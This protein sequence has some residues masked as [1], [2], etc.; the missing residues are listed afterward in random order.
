MTIS[1]NCDHLS[2]DRACDIANQAV[3]VGGNDTIHIGL[4]RV[5]ETTTVALARLVAL[6]RDLRRSGRD[7][8]IA[9]LHG[10]AANVLP[11]E[12]LG[13]RTQ[14]AL[15]NLD[16]AEGGWSKLYRDPSDGRLWELTFPNSEWHGGGPPCLTCISREKAD[17]KYGDVDG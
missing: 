9:G 2:Y 4:H 12:D 16:V 7:L 14:T 1:C 6:R 11:S 17:G 13:A 8:M 5:V 10:Q 3:V 15:E